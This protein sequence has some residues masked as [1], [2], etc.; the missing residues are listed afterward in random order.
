MKYTTAL[1]PY[2][3]N[4]TRYSQQG[5]CNGSAFFQKVMNTLFKDE[6]E[7]YVFVYID[8]IFIYSNIKK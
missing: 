6:L 8:D 4:R 5:D 2:G 3:T 1:T 7:I